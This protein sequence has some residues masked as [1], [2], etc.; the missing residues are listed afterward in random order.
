MRLRQL[1][2]ENLRL[3]CTPIINL[4]RHRAAPIKLGT[5]LSEYILIPDQLSDA[6]SDIY[7]VDKVSLLRRT[8]NDEKPLEFTQFEG[9]SPGDTHWQESR[10]EHTLSLIDRAGMALGLTTGTLAVQLTCTNRDLPQ[11]LGCGALRGD[12]VTEINTAGLPIRLLSK[13]SLRQQTSG[14]GNHWGLISPLVGPSGLTDLIE[15][16]RLHAPV[17]STATQHLLQGLTALTIH[18]ANAWIGTRYTHGTEYHLQINERFFTDRSI[19]TFAEILASYFHQ[20]AYQGR[21]SQLIIRSSNA[22]I[23]SAGR[24]VGKRSLI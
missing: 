12:L 19:C 22:E 3:G 7:S 8:S 14:V 2:R 18:P 17:S 5:E 23:L 15:L 9:I 13:P 16:L 4:F 6:A 1:T 24:L 10:S 20:H 11:S 21:Y